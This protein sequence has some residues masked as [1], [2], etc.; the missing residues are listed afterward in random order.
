M[1]ETEVLDLTIA[2]A[3]VKS[4]NEVVT[5]IVQALQNFAQ[6][7]GVADQ[8]NSKQ[9]EEDLAIFLVKRRVVNLTELRATILEGGDIQ[10]GNT[11]KG[12]RKAD[13]IVKLHYKEGVHSR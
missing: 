5:A 6:K 9:I 11:I 1:S 10:L 8:F 2:T 7:Y 3:E 13:L 12:N 4:I